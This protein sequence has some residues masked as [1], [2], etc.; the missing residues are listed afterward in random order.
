MKT[1]TPG[2]L[3]FTG[4]LMLISLLASQAA[5]DR[6][7]VTTAQMITEWQRAKEFTKE[8]LDVMP[9]EGTN[10]K[11]TPEIRSFAEQMLHLANGNFNFASAASGKPNPYQ[12]KNLEKLDEFKTKAALSK[13]VLESYDFTIDALKATT[14]AQMAEQ[15]KLFGKDMSREMAFAKEFEHQTHHRGQTTIY[16]RMKGVKPPNEKLF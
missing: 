6:S 12:G 9:E 5:G 11:P 1:K 10:Y 4:F 15:I 16:I 13:V 2:R 7:T 3:L 14:D 8:Y